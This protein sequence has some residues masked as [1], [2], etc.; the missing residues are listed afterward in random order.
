MAADLKRSVSSLSRELR[1]NS[2]NGQYDPEAA[3]Q[4]AQE[5][6]ISQAP[7]KVMTQAMSLVVIGLMT[8]RKW[9]PEQVSG[10]LRKAGFQ[11][12]PCAVTIYKHIHAMRAKAASCTTSSATKASGA[13]RPTTSATTA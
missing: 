11:D 7:R 4:M 3:H 9:S 10:R 12:V 6:R 5:R 2:V 13:E 1:R 8:L